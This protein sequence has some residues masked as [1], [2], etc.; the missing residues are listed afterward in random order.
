MVYRGLQS[1][2]ALLIIYFSF[3]AKFVT[4]NQINCGSEIW[5]NIYNSKKLVIQ[6]ARLIGVTSR[7]NMIIAAVWNTAH[8]IHENWHQIISEKG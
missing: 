2:I 3:S 8:Y 5:H 7:D 4:N 6:I 1:L